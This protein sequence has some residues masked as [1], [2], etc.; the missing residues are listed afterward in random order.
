MLVFQPTVRKQLVGIVNPLTGD[1]CLREDLMQEAMIHLWKVE[2]ERPGQTL[3]WYLQSCSFHLRHYL[4]SGRSIDSS[5]RC[6]LQI[7]LP[8]D[9]DLH[10][11]PEWSP[12]EQ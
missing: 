7:E 12:V 5:K 9:G 11:C 10:S 1:C 2:G 8:E 6:S 4:A 3:S